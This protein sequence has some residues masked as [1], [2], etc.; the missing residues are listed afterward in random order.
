MRLA[1]IVWLGMAGLGLLLA[2][3]PNDNC[4]NA[5]LITFPN[6]N[7]GLGVFY[8]D[9]VDIT[10]ATLQPGEYIPPGVPNGKTVWYRFFIPTTRTVRIILRQVGTSIDP[11]K[12]GWTLYRTNSCLPGAAQRVDPPIVLMEGYTHACLRRGWYL[13]QVGADF[14]VSGQIFLELQVDAPRIDAGAEANYDHAATAQNLGVLNTLWWSSLVKD[15]SFEVACQSVHPGEAIC[16]NDSSWSK[17]TWHVFRTDGHIDWLGIRI[18]EDPWN[19]TE[20][21]PREWRVFLYQ[22]D[23]RTDPNSLTLIEGCIPFQQVGS[24]AFPQHDF[25]CQLQPNTYYTIRIL[26]RTNYS[27]NVR[28]Q[29]FERGEGPSI[30]TNPSTLPASHQFGVLSMG[31]T[32]TAYDKWSCNARISL[33]RCGNLTPT[34]TINGRDLALYYTFTITGQVHVYLSSGGCGATLRLFRTT[35]QPHATIT[36]PTSER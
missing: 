12:A 31:P 7:Y 34:D 35:I 24:W 28:L 6:N 23:A 14:A 32:Y 36:T 21:T 33:N 1:N 27:G 2:Q 29:L 3:P 22:G 8:S 17:S 30:G 13:V 15:V 26:Y 16:D 25:L 18:G 19:S 5:S 9:T 4:A 20:T 10:G 11:T